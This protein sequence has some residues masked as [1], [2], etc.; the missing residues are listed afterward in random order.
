MTEHTEAI[1]E[2][3]VL[4]AA[5]DPH[6]PENYS[7]LLECS[8]RLRHAVRVKLESD[9][10]AVLENPAYLGDGVY[11]SFDGYQ[12]ELST[13][14]ADR[15]PVPDRIYLEPQVL[16]ALLVFVEACGVAKGGV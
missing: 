5:I 6:K 7:A 10:A 11:A 8:S 13:N 16:R 2:A 9:A 3:A 1:V 15:G 14:R 12:I 4:F